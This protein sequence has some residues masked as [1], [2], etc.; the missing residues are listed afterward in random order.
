MLKTVKFG[1]SSL[2][3]AEQ[4]K[5]A[6]QIIKQDRARR[7]VVPSAPGKRFSGDAKVTD[8]LINCHKAMGAS[9]KIEILS[10]IRMRYEEIISGL[11]LALSLDSEFSR[12]IQALRQ[13]AD[14]DYMASRGE[15]L[16]GM[17]LAEALGYDFLDPVEAIVFSDEGR[18]LPEITQEKLSTLLGKHSRAVIPGFYGAKLDGRIITFSRGGSDVTGAIVAH[19]CNADVYE[20]WTDVSGFKMANPAIVPEAKQIQVLSY[21]ELRELSYMGA[22]VLHEDSIF[23][24]RE[25]GIPIHIRNTN[26]PFDEGTM[27]VQHATHHQDQIITG[28]AGKKDFTFIMIEKSMMNNELGFGRKVLSVLEE[29]GISFEHMPTGID[30]LSV[31]VDSATIDG[32]E[33]DIVREI[34]KRVEPD[35]IELSDKMAIIAT[36]GHNMVRNPGTAAK[37]FTALAENQINVRMIDQGSSEMNI[38]V[39]VENEDYEKAVRAIYYAFA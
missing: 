39:G 11:G 21:R 8:L 29:R 3:S 1:G 6:I 37:L 12:I 16:N 38:I 18:F 33:E 9:A 14:R 15:Y 13:G 31:A 28:I 17:I 20:N 24:V 32:K 25:A 19:A 26:D 10:R 34:M 5:K 30:S 2:A 36:V 27:I 35:H 22:N 23:P 7:Y 4:M